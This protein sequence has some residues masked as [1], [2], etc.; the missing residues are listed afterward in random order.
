MDHLRKMNAMLRFHFKID[1]DA[2]SDEEFAMRWHE[3][4]W[5]LNQQKGIEQ[6]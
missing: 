3:L 5:I 4:V 2:L 1:P 6:K